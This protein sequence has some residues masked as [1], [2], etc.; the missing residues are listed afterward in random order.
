VF[1]RYNIISVLSINNISCMFSN[2]RV[3]SM[4]RVII[5]LRVNSMN[6]MFRVIRMMCVIS[7]IK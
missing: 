1:I 3:N 2:N 6:S 5:Y 4:N 7:V